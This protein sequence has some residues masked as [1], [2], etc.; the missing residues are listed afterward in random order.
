V[1]EEGAHDVF[2][3]QNGWLKLE[4]MEEMNPNFVSSITYKKI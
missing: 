4:N 2:K 1:H 3:A